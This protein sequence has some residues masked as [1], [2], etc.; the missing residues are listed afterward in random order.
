MAAVR[1]VLP[2]STWPMVPTLR[3][4]LERSNVPAIFLLAR[5]E[6][7][8]RERGLPSFCE[9]IKTNNS[10]EDTS[11]QKKNAPSANVTHHREEQKKV[12]PVVRCHKWRAHDGVSSSFA[13]NSSAERKGLFNVESLPEKEIHRTFVGD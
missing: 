7:L 3:C 6:K 5:R 2:W 8:V 1:V 10:A 9:Q 4:G 11:L 12:N 13:G